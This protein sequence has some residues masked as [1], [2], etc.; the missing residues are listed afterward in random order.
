M[1]KEAHFQMFTGYL[2]IIFYEVAVQILCPFF[3]WVEGLSKID[4]Q[5]FVLYSKYESFVEYTCCKSTSSVGCFSLLLVSFNKQ[6]LL[7]L[8]QSDFFF[9]VGNFVSHLRNHPYSK[10]Q[11][12]YIFL[13]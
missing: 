11:L 10:S 6:K 4:L 8:I 5:V 7:I 13:K 2:D 12:F 3:Y 1:N 9:L